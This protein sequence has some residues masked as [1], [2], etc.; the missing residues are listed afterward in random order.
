MLNYSSRFGT[1]RIK[2]MR[3]SACGGLYVARAVWL[4][5]WIDWA[6]YAVTVGI[7]SDDRSFLSPT[8]IPQRGKGV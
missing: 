7:F 2:V 1:V 8:V 3:H 6:V 4:D 5:G